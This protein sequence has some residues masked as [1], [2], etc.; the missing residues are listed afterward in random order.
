MT[1]P[2][3]VTDRL[4]EAALTLADERGWQALAMVDVAKRADVPLLDCYRI[5]PDK[6]ALLCRLLAATDEAVLR[7]GAA[8]PEEAPRDRL[9]DVVMRRFDALQARRPGTVA[10]LRDLP[11]DP[12]SVARLLPRLA[13]SLVWMLE[14]AGVSTI[15]LP[16]AL[17]V[18]GLG[19]VYLYAL[20]AWI[21]DDTPD[22]ARTMAALDRAL[23]NAE[24]LARRLP[25]GRQHA[26][27]DSWHRADIESPAPPSP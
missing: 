2:E 14:S 7:D 17:R 22:M 21:D 9:F 11:F 18:K 6:A 19:V 13:R 27:D 25:S 15:G 12:A 23:R 26:E 10:I 24:R 8:D 20:R 16:G 3:S 1:E 4:T 5:F